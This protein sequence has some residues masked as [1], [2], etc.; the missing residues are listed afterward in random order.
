MPLLMYGFVPL[1]RGPLPL[2][3]FPPI[4]DEA[5]A[6]AAAEDDELAAEGDGASEMKAW[7]ASR[8]IGDALMTLTPVVMSAAAAARRKLVGATMLCPVSVFSEGKGER[9]CERGLSSLC[10][11]SIYTRGSEGEGVY[12]RRRRCR[13]P[14]ISKSVVW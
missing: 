11:L 5:E 2:F 3:A 10:S 8:N 14:C 9:S 6:V 12:R 1:P 13:R 4:P 7:A